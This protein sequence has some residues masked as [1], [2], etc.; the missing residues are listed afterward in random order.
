MD[1]IEASIPLT[2]LPS[3]KSEQ[4]TAQYRDPLK[5]LPRPA[6]YGHPVVQDDLFNAQA[7]NI[8]MRRRVCSKVLHSPTQPIPTRPNSPLS[9]PMFEDQ[10]P[11]LSSFAGSAFGTNLKPVVIA[12]DK[13]TQALLDRH[14]ISWG[15]QY[16]LARGV[17]LGTWT[18]EE[19]KEKIKDLTGDNAHAAFQVQIIMRGKPAA[20][21]NPSNFYLWYVPSHHSSINWIQAS[22]VLCLF[23]ERA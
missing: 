8:T 20:S 1:S 19:V 7:S 17:S 21:P 23:Q 5:K 15:T 16:E 4:T 11:E 6:I 18:W 3:A 10:I 14:Q 13:E 2:K 9:P 12:H 22:G